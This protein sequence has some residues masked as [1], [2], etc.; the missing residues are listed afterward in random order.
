MTTGLFFSALPL[1]FSISGSVH[2]E[3]LPL[4]AASS[5]VSTSAAKATVRPSEND[6]SLALFV[7]HYGETFEFDPQAAVVEAEMHGP[8]EVVRI[9][10]IQRSEPPDFI[11]HR[12]SPTAEDFR[13]ENFEKLTL[14]ELLVIPKGL[15]GTSKTL[16]EMKAAK[17]AQLSSSPT[18]YRIL[19]KPQGSPDWPEGSFEVVTDLPYRLWQIYAE[20]PKEFLIYSMGTDPSLQRQGVSENNSVA[21]NLRKRTRETE[22]TDLIPAPRAA[23]VVLALNG[24]FALI[25]GIPAAFGRRRRR[26]LG[27]SLLGFCDGVYALAYLACSADA[28]FSI[29]VLQRARD[30]QITAIVIVTLAALALARHLRAPNFKVV[31]TATVLAA[32]FVIH[33]V[34]R[35]RGSELILPPLDLIHQA[36]VAFVVFFL[37]LLPAIVYG[38]LLRLPEAES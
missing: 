20:A 37:A 32:I 17:A 12:F 14:R 2:A 22:W 15:P 16:A 25:A 6:P 13:P 27:L 18:R 36:D 30:V 29:G 21:R 35:T 3:S 34:I 31:G 33:D 19:D 26:I 23:A 28:A 11:P 1:L 5:S 4:S 24:L 7:G 38:S 8:I 9:H 10:D